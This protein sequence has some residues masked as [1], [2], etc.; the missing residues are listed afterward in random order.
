MKR[1]LVVSGRSGSGKS[2]ALHVLEDMGFYCI[3]NLPL[4][5]LPPPLV[6]GPIPT[7]PPPLGGTDLGVDLGTVP[8][9]DMGTTPPP[10]TGG[11]CSV[12]VVAAPTAS[13]WPAPVASLGLALGV[14][15][16]L[17]RRRRVAA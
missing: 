10:S 16:R 12:A 4:S 1:I 3:D 2:S 9:V 5:L 13:S 6:A 8:P 7:E 14:A 17:C 11:G 15:L